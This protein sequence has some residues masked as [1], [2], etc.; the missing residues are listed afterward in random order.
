MSHP[1]KERRE[2]PVGGTFGVGYS[3]VQIM[4]DRAAIR[5]LF[6]DGTGQI[7]CICRPQGTG[8]AKLDAAGHGSRV[9]D[10][11]RVSDCGRALL[12]VGIRTI[13]PVDALDQA[14]L[15][16]PSPCRSD[17]L[18]RCGLARPVEFGPLHLP[19]DAVG[20][21]R[22]P[23]TCHASCACRVGLVGAGAVLRREGKERRWARFDKAPS[24]PGAGLPL[25]CENEKIR[26]RRSRPVEV[27]NLGWTTRRSVPPKG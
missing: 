3:K 26:E 7:R 2:G 25:A 6:S 18:S 16:P 14:S 24:G 10:C 19:S 4:V 5:V 8:R 17:L 23:P 27:C 1:D 20:A 9:S 13:R 11:N 15:P 21:P 12:R 22:T